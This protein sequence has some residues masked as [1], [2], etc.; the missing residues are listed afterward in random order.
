MT[1]NT[2]EFMRTLHNASLE[3]LDRGLAVVPLGIDTKKPLAPWKEFQTRL[4]T[5]EEVDDWFEHGAPTTKG[6]RVKVFNIAIVTGSL[7]G[8]LV[9]DCDN[10]SAIDFA[11]KN[12]L[13]SPFAVKTTRGSHYYFQHPRN[14]ARFKN[15]VGGAARMWPDVP[16][17]DF[18]GDGGYVVAPPSVSFNKDGSFKHVYSWE[19]GEGLDW[20]DCPEWKGV[21]EAIEV[22]EDGTF[23][24]SDLK[25][26]GVEV[27]LAVADI[28]EQVRNKVAL[29]GRK[30]QEGDSTDMWMIKYC[31][32][33]VRRGVVGPD[34]KEKVEEFYGQY[35]S[36]SYS[37]AETNEW[38]RT[39]IASALHMDRANYPDDYDDEGKRV[40]PTP[41]KTEVGSELRPIYAADV[42]RVLDALG[43]TKY[44]ADPILPSGNIVQVVGFNGHGK[45]FFLN[46]LLT[47]NTAGKGEFGPFDFP[48]GRSRVLY[49][50]FDNPPRT[51]LERLKRF[52]A[53]YGGTNEHLAYWSPALI[54][55]E[56]GGAMNLRE[57][58]GRLVMEAWL[59]TCKPNIVV[60]D[61][62]RNAFGGMEENTPH[63]WYIVN[64]LAKLIRD[65]YDATVVLVH[66]RNK[67]G[68]TGLG[69]EAGSTAQ[70]TDVDTQ[71]MVTQVYM[72]KQIAKAKAGLLDGDLH[73]YDINGDD[74]TPH[75]YLEQRLEADSRLRMV[76]Q[77]SYGK[78]RNET[79]L[80][81]THYIGWAE[82]L[83]DGSTY[84]VST[85]SKKQKAK[86]FASKGKTPSDI[87][88][89][90]MVPASLVSKW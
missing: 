25:L 5:E 81:E 58:E 35:F 56:E 21:P 67:P 57:A 84:I 75:G 2:D 77:I 31:G 78:V 63:E 62:V 23:E 50:D 90:L 74:W 79:E 18:R 13:H 11:Q 51:L 42:D 73:V 88:R 52:T 70:L 85:S 48:E 22:I 89:E 33:L 66:H 10:Q 14:G 30:L 8:V 49:F 17:L 20:E 54:S 24:F 12:Y 4:P 1:K 60:I 61:T 37:Q 16:G 76:S 41:K 32:Q 36:D 34:L 6:D 65:K 80:H 38:I 87:A 53:T 71:V 47:A 43:E 19:I 39:K 69:R 9:L 26:H 46:A 27:S 68:E 64:R 55:P 7:S 28:E 29:L 40:S 15:A 82:R 72:E 59:E 86:Y 44:W 83:T 3:Y 45:S